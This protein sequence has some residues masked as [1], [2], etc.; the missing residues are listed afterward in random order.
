M[1][2]TFV[3]LEGI[4]VFA[5]ELLKIWVLPI[6]KAWWWVLPPFLL[7]KPARFFWLWWRQE[8]AWK[9]RKWV[10]LEIK[11]PRE[12]LKPIKAM[13]EVFG[14]FYMVATDNEPGNFR[15][16]WIEGCTTFFPS[17]SLESVS[18]GG[19]IHF[20]IR[21][22]TAYRDW[23]ESAIYSQYP[24]VE[25]TEAEDYTQLVPQDIP[26]S[27]WNLEGKDFVLKKKDC[28][29]IKTYEQFETGT[30]TKE[31]KRVDPMA[32]L[33]EALSV[34]K[35]GEQVWIQILLNDPKVNKPN[36]DWVKE[37]E[38]VR[39]KLV[40]RPGAPPPPKPMIQEAIEIIRKGAAEKGE[41]K[42]DKKGAIPPEMRVTPG[43]RG[44]GKEVEKKIS[45]PGFGATI[46]VVYLGR[47]DVFFK[48]HIALPIS[49]IVA[50]NTS[51]LNRFGTLDATNT[52][53]KSVFFW[54]D[55][56]RAFLKKRKMFRNYVMRLTPLFPFRGGTSVLNAEELAS[57]FHFPGRTSAPAPFAP[58][59][60]VKGGEA[61]P[62]LPVE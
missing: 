22:E 56:R 3:Q 24:E 23:I 37:G 41:K 45:K 40:K 6:I 25:I 9:E 27:K 58:R 33:L 57:L 1:T 11:L 43:E 12:T 29:P 26:N 36:Y 4:K 34:L 13:E 20:Y 61:P 10:L 46:R 7:I 5:L 17:L 50:F 54:L 39:D 16:K 32:K 62:G 21:T 49:F 14:T 60:E 38:A 42:E 30:E 51:H 35:E 47:R 59:I 52:K 55:E 28:Y 19:Q 8:K 15:E 48:P 53:V 2:D 31:E 18:L 44:I